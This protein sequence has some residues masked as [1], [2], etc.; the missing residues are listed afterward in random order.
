MA[1]A[2]PL[3]PPIDPRVGDPTS[4]AAPDPLALGPSSGRA[5]HS[6]RSAGQVRPTIPQ[7]LASLSVALDLT[8]GLPRQ[9]ATRT[10]LLAL[11]VGRAWRLDTSTLD[12]LV[13]ASV[14]KDA[15]CSSNAA[16]ITRIF[17]GDDIAIKTRYLLTDR[18]L[19]ARIRFALGVLPDAEPL[20]LRAR[21]LVAM[22][23]RGPQLQRAVEHLRCERGA[24]IARRIG[25]GEEVARAVHDVHEHWDGRGQPAG[26]RGEEIHPLARIVAACAGLDAIWRVQGRAAARSEMRRRRGSWYEP[27]VVDTLIELLDRGRLDP[28]EREAPERIREAIGTA[29]GQRLATDAEIDQVALGF[30][31]IVDA[32]SPYTGRHSKRASILARRLAE[33]LGLEEAT[34]AD[35]ARAALLHDIG[36]L[37]V[38]NSILDKPSQLTAEEWEIVRRH[39]ALS[40]E[41]LS[42][43]PGFQG[44]ADMAASHHERLDGRG[45]FRGRAG[46][47]I[48]IGARIVAVADVFEA[49]TA[50]RPYRAPMETDE[51]I[52]VVQ[53]LAGDHLAIEVVAVLPDAVED[54]EG[55][56]EP[57]V[58]PEAAHPLGTPTARRP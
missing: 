43:I 50:H 8:E 54:L 48:S 52:A 42:P 23:L 36:K 27:A 34:A 14:L 45:Y 4:S 55:W 21:R 24:S 12:D 11:E 9:H 13:V 22:A 7:L 10:A 30:A 5:A 20:P 40:W 2:R 38:P 39:P 25:F 15:G 16:A 26:R 6:S 29:V 47:A 3:Q 17:G 46:D 51:A 58:P 41:I 19:L 53:E 35:V 49:L 1:L 57:L 56:A 33:R 28:I 37:G 18:S 32:K 31:D 44:V